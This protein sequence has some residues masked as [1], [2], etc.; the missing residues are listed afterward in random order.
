MYYN[1]VYIKSSYFRMVLKSKEIT[2]T[3]RKLVCN[4]QTNKTISTKMYH[5]QYNLYLSL[6]Y[7]KKSKNKCVE[8]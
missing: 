7:F 5:L 4:S 8:R 3:D 1:M 2:A 6:F